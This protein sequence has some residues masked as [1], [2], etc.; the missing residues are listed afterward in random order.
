MES[1]LDEFAGQEDAIRQIWWSIVAGSGAKAEPGFFQRVQAIPL[2]FLQRAIRTGSIQPIV[3]SDAWKR[4]LR[5]SF[6]RHTPVEAR[7]LRGGMRSALRELPRDRFPKRVADLAFH[8]RLAQPRAVRLVQAVNARNRAGIRSLVGYASRDYARS[9]NPALL[10][11]LA[12]DIQGMIGLTPW[13]AGQLR[14]RWRNLRSQGMAPVEIRRDIHARAAK[15]IERR[16]YQIGDRAVLENVGFARHQT[17]IE[18]QD[19]GDIPDNALKQWHDQRDGKERRTH[20]EQTMAGAIPLREVYALHGVQ[21][22]PSPDFGCRCWEVLVLG[23]LP[24]TP[25]EIDLG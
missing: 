20:R 9:P 23:D 14:K 24:A 5:W 6:G 22:P 1:P 10:H 18:L 4:A 12:K 11:A 19:R 3:R 8:Q 15:Y 17:W 25:E 13:Q 7:L 21:H 2:I 16:S